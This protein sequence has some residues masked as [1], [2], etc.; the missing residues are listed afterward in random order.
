MKWRAVA[1][2]R[3]AE[4]GA[5]L[6]PLCASLDSDVSAAV[7]EACAEHPDVVVVVGDDGTVTRVATHLYEQRRDE[8][9]VPLLLV[10]P[11]GAVTAVAEGVGA[12]SSAARLRRHL[13]AGK[14]GVR[15]RPSLRVVDTSHPATRLAFNVGMGLPFD[16]LAAR[17]RS[18]RGGRLA[19]VEAFARTARNDVAEGELVEADVFADWKPYAEH[20][21]YLLVS[22]GAHGWFGVEMGRG[23]SFRLG[24][25]ALELFESRSRVGRLMQRA[26]GRGA[27]SFERIHIDTNSGY[28]LDGELFDPR[29]PRTIAVSAGPS[30][31]FATI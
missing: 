27:E 24:R 26:T 31:R 11:Q 21:R 23:P 1:D 6:H 3:W 18:E 8:A 20:L 10:V 19:L 14:L 7:D 15:T 9:T 29:I 22:A 25:S 13:E 4:V 28:V 2:A 12:P 16:F 17:A 5:Q 30:L